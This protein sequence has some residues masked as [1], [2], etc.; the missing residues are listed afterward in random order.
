VGLIVVIDTGS[1]AVRQQYEDLGSAR[2]DHLRKVF[3]ATAV[4]HLEILNCRDYI[5][6]ADERT[7][8]VPGKSVGLVR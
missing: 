4:D 8:W 2:R 6:L 7:C 5:R 3:R 1:K